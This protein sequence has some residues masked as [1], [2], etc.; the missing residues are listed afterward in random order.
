MW[1]AG[2]QSDG[3]Y[4]ALAIHPSAPLLAATLRDGTVHVFDDEGT[5][6]EDL[7]L[8]K[9]SVPTKV[10]WHPSKKYLA[11]A[12]NGGATPANRWAAMRGLPLGDAGLRD[13]E[14]S[15]LET[16]SAA[17][18]LEL[19]F[20]ECVRLVCGE[21][22][23]S[24]VG[25][26]PRLREKDSPPF[27][28]A[29]Q[30][31]SIYYADDMGHCTESTVSPTSI[32]ALFV[33]ESLD[34]LLVVTEDLVLSRFSLAIDGKMTQDSSVCLLSSGPSAQS[35]RGFTALARLP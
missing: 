23:M 16:H 2:P 21:V 28:L 34:T 22:L 33:A 7:S 20:M 32:H 18:A 30:S 6:L 27:F 8:K 9:D 35:Q 11:V 24:R 26:E 29:G 4:Q 10:V 13:P 12:W 1:V 25:Q 17:C 14:K 15:T 19:A 3:E 5:R 31:G